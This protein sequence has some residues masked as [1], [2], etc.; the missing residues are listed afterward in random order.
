MLQ[1]NEK[2]EL[3]RWENKTVIN[4]NVTKKIA[5]CYKVFKNATDIYNK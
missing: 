2:N 5:I 1:K 4:E 3:L